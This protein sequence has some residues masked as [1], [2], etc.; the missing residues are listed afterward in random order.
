MGDSFYEYLLKHWLITGKKDDRT[1]RE[2]DEAVFAMEKKQLFQSEP[3]KL[4]FS[5]PFVSQSLQVFRR[6]ERKSRGT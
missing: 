2:Y 6:L 3:G 5:S 4:W 1:K